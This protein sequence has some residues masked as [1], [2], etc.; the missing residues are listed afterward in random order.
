M[1][2]PPSV[3]LVPAV[4]SCAVLLLC[5]LPP[6]VAAEGLRPPDPA[7]RRVLSNYRDV[8]NKVLAQLANGDWQETVEFEITDEVMVSGDPDVPLDV[9]E[10]IQRSYSVR[11]GS[12][13]YEREVAPFAERMTS[14]GDPAEMARIA[15]QMKM[16]RFSVQVHFN[17]PNVSL[18][19]PADR[20]ELRVPGVA[21]A[22][23]LKTD[24]GTSVALL[25]GNWKTATWDAAQGWDHFHFKHAAHQ[26]AIE[27]AV[28]RLD[29]SPERIQELLHSVDWTAVNGALSE[30]P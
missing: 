18:D 23:R 26:P 25:F 15:K 1:R 28:I 10:S 30:Q 2:T 17:Q 16:T 20:S 6:F 9:N 11:R 12:A 27:N 14:S 5:G 29:G 4:A 21:H 22:Y 13:L 24:R 7:E 3:L 8:L 19:P